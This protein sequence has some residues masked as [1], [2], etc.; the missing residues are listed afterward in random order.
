MRERGRGRRCSTLLWMPCATLLRF[1]RAPVG[2]AQGTG[3]STDP[4][5]TSAPPLAAQPPYMDPTQEPTY[6]GRLLR[7]AGDEGTAYSPCSAPS[8]RWALQVRPTYS[9]VQ[10]W[11]ANGSLLAI[12][13]NNA[14]GLGF[15]PSHMLLDGSTYHVLDYPGYPYAGQGDFRWHPDGSAPYFQ[16]N[17]NTDGS[18]LRWVDVRTGIGVP[19]KRWIFGPHALQAI[20]MGEGNPS[21]D[22]RF[23]ALG[24]TTEITT[25]HFV[26][27]V[28]AVDMAQGRIGDTSW[29]VPDCG[30]APNDN[31]RVGWFSISPDGKF[32][33]VKY[34]EQGDSTGDNKD[35]IR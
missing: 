4:Q 25:D 29:T 30:L 27:H 32:L 34:A 6:G 21:D 18:E 15:G 23:V 7:I 3:V 14:Q 35:C 11:N 19:G 2:R 22:G 33:V 8:C 20:G 16:I 17:V 5:T 28:F 10:P 31:C 1:A 12:D 9:K 13:N 24:R 26:T